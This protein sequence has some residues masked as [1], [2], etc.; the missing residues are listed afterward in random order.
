LDPSQPRDTSAALVDAGRAVTWEIGVDWPPQGLE[1][2]AGAPLSRLSPPQPPPGAQPPDSR[3]G[4]MRENVRD[5]VVRLTALFAGA[6]GGDREAVRVHAAALV[7]LGRLAH[8][9]G[10]RE[11]ADL[12]FARALEVRP[13]HVAALVNRGALA[14]ERGDAEA[15]L[16]FTQRALA[17]AP[18]HVGARI[19]AARALIRLN[20]DTRARAHI[21]RALALAP[22]R[23]AAWALSALLDL[24][25]GRIAPALNALD[26]AQALDPSDPDALSVAEQLRRA[27]QR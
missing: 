21:D 7:G 4:R 1:L 23:A 25:A 16:A 6:A 20:R 22:D 18:N 15:A 17:R 12:V 2:V 10:D 14:A 9:R 5:A 24:R 27:Q 13:G 11:L 19:N 8:Q 26:R 3:D